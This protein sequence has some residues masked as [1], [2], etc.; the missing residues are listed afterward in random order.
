[1]I[2]E[3]G[4]HRWRDV[5]AVTEYRTKLSHV[6]QEFRTV[7]Q[8]TE[9]VAGCLHSWLSYALDVISPAQLT[10]CT[11]R[12]DFNMHFRLANLCS[13]DQNACYEDE[14]MCHGNAAAY[15]RACRHL[16]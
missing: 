1:M 2:C 5:R 3:T 8:V 4:S 12:T 11:A 14:C 7:A 6:F 10:T 13:A 9:F 16:L 15:R